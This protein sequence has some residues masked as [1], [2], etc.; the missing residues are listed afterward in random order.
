MNARQ[1]QPG[2]VVPGC[3]MGALLWEQVARHMGVISRAASRCPAASQPRRGPAG[4]GW[5]G[6]AGAGLCNL[7]LQHWVGAGRGVPT[8]GIHPATGWEGDRCARKMSMDISMVFAALSPAAQLGSEFLSP[9][10]KLSLLQ[11]TGCP[12]KVPYPS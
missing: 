8:G 7:V 5:P 11:I 9:L 10:A 4:A 6:C 3:P 1:M 2:P 12:C